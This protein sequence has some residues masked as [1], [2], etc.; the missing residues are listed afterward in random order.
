MSP[1]V[2][3]LLFDY[4]TT[5]SVLLLASLNAAKFTTFSFSPFVCH[6]VSGPLSALPMECESA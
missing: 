2:W 1:A 4:L 6:F 3:A 5:A